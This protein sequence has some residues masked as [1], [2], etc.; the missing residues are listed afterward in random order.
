MVRKEKPGSREAK[1]GQLNAAQ[2]GGGPPAVQEEGFTYK[3]GDRVRWILDMD[4]DGA[5]IE[6]HAPSGRVRLL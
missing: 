2:Q 4:L 3:P 6:V 5:E 1:R